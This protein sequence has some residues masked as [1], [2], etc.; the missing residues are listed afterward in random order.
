MVSN[1]TK[2]VFGCIIPKNDLPMKTPSLTPGF[3]SVVGKLADRAENLLPSLREGASIHDAAMV[4]AMEECQ[5]IDSD[6][7]KIYAAVVS[8]LFSRKKLTEFFRKR[9]RLSATVGYSFAAH[10]AAALEEIEKKAPVFRG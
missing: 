10:S 7:A 6:S 9:T 4:V 8:E 3:Q 2:R 1:L 5:R